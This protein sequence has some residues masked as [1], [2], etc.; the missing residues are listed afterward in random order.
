VDEDTPPAPTTATGRI[1]LEAEERVSAAR[2][3]ATVV[4]FS[5]IY[6]PG[7]NWLIDRVRSGRPVQADPPSYTNRIHR[8]DCVG[9]L[10]H[11]LDRSL[12]GEAVPPVILASDDDPAPLAEVSAWLA[13]RLGVAPPPAAAA[14]ADA[15]RN[16]RCRHDRLRN[17]GYTF[18]YRSY[19]EGYAHVLERME[20]ES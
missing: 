12:A 1:M 18:R 7:R 9:V 19:R 15:P 13:G 11:L 6:G 3:D 20:R 14:D 8:D 16:K 4:R 10:A 17:L 5:G 2:P